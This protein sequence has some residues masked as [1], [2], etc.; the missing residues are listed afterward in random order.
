MLCNQQINNVSGQ[1]HT[2]PPTLHGPVSSCVQGVLHT[3]YKDVQDHLYNGPAHAT[4]LSA[5][6]QGD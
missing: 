3:H 4:R 5:F 1:T 6:L 2:F